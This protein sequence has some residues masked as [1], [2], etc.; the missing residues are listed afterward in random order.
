MFSDLFHFVARAPLLV[1]LAA[2]V[3]VFAASL[4]SKDKATALQAVAMMLAVTLITV[5]IFLRPK[6]APNP[7]ADIVTCLAA[8]LLVAPGVAS[9][10]KLR[11]KPPS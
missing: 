9:L 4:K 6:P 1:S 5:G 3:V 2:Q 8:I 10:A 7:A 11:P